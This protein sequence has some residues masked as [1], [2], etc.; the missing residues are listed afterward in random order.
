M[1]KIFL[2]LALFLLAELYLIGQIMDEWGV[3]TT[4]LALLLTAMVGSRLVKLEAITTIRTLASKLQEKSSIGLELLEGLALL[5]AGFLFIFPGFISDGL[6]LLLLVPPLRRLLL[7]FFVRSSPLFQPRASH[8]S[9]KDTIIEGEATQE[10]DPAQPPILC[11]PLNDK[12][13]PQ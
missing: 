5:I 8:T 7:I 12:N 13:T 6:A 9:A 2:F 1:S 11:L 3:L 4:L 10:R